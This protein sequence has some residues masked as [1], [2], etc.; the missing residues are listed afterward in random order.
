MPP[1]THLSQRIPTRG[2]AAGERSHARHAAPAAAAPESGRGQ[3]AAFFDFDGTLVSTNLVHAYWYYA[4]NNQGL[5]KSFARSVE[6]LVKVPVF[7]AANSWD[8]QVFNEIFFKM[9][10]GESADRLRYLSEEICEDVLKPAVYPGA[11]ELIRRVKAS[12][13]KPIIISGAPDF[14]LRPIAAH[15]GVEE[16]ACNR[17]EFVDGRCTGRMLPPVMAAATKAA[18]IREWAEE[19]GVRL[20]DCYS[21]A[22]SY[23]DLP[24]L[25]VVG[26]PAAVNPDLR[27]K[28]V[29]KRHHWPVLDLTGEAA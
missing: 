4:R 18:W 14:T 25:S 12:G 1:E 23:S 7:A 11:I 15:L 16:Y 6:T 20:S 27:L 19:R 3:P 9:Y 5:W 13:I 8:R 22:D 24:M 29:A 21:Y 2:H 28:S 17:L 26:H 10:T